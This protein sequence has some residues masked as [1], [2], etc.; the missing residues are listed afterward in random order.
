MPGLFSDS[1]VE[2]DGWGGRCINGRAASG[3]V[4]ESYGQSR[5][6]T[7]ASTSAM[8][9]DPMGSPVLVLLLK[10]ALVLV[11]VPAPVAAL[12]E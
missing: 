12:A 4:L 11:R 3:A 6:N 10:L 8:S 5:A 9:S 2:T 7:S 1:S